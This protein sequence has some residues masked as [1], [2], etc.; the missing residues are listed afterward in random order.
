MAVLEF[1]KAAPEVDRRGKYITPLRVYRIADGSLAEQPDSTGLS[2]L[3][4]G[5]NKVVTD[6]VDQ[7]A[8]MEL[9]APTEKDAGAA[10]ENKDAGA[11]PTNKAAKTTRRKKRSPRK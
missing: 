3:A 11:A 9:V 1:N 5:K 7:A 4:Y 8:I 10:P 6:E 2:K